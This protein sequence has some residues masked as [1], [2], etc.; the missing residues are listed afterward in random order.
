MLRPRGGQ[1]FTADRLAAPFVVEE[2]S[3]RLIELNTHILKVE[4]PPRPLAWAVFHRHREH[5][6]DN[7]C[8]FQASIAHGVEPNVFKPHVLKPHV[9]PLHA[10]V[11]QLDH[12]A[13]P[14]DGIEHLHA[15][16]L[17][18]RGMVARTSA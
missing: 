8:A 4:L 15:E 13:V 12:R 17:A 18:H 7:P 6:D 5:A 14:F 2:P 10:V 11:Q 1:V 9:R 16:A 3:T